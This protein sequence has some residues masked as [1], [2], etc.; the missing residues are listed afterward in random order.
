V[1]NESLLKEA[2]ERIAEQGEG[3]RRAYYNASIGIPITAV[4]KMEDAR[5]VLRKVYNN[6]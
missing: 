4:A 5:R 2:L 6:D 1:D 3:C